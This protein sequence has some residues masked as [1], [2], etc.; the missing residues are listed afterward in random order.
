MEKKN[1][2][3]KKYV[4]LRTFDGNFL[5]TLDRSMALKK[6]QSFLSLSL[7]RRE[8]CRAREMA[9]V[10]VIALHVMGDLRDDGSLSKYYMLIQTA[11][12]D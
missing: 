1:V 3:P 8:R 9:W 6:K 2:F 10:S 4:E 7:K 12:I 11:G 5:Y